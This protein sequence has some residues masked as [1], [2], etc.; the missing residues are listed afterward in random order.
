MA[1]EKFTSNGNTTVWLIPAN[2][3]ADY[4]SPTAAEINAGMDI[5]PAIAWEGTTFPTATESEDQDDRSLR[6]KGN[7]TT[8]GAASYEAVLN[9][10]Y[11]KNLQDNNSDYGKVY[12]ML[13]V[14]RV[15]VFVV[16][17]I[18]QAP[19][20][21]HKNAEAGE[22][23]SVFRFVSDGWTDDFEGDDSNKYAIGMLTQGE[24]AIY[25]QVKGSTPVAVTKVGAGPAKVS[26]GASIVLRATLNG[27]RASQV[28]E[29]HSSDSS[30]ATVSPN[31]VVTG[32]ATGSVDIT[33]SHPAASAPSTALSVTVGS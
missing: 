30:M 16:T 17:R 28:V 14:P 5:T 31:G 1:D 12:N 2:G 13:R 20:G 4:R 11:P 25:T 18:A 6:D 23:V 9:L 19:E 10:F 3:I 22:W 21:E 8:R 7:A 26:V 27:K 15:P 24:V 32:V 33:A 29:W